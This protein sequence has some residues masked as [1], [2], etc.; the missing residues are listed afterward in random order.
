MRGSEIFP[1]TQRGTVRGLRT[2]AWGPRRCFS[3]SSFDPRTTR[4]FL[5]VAAMA[6]SGWRRRR[7]AR[8]LHLSRPRAARPARDI[9][10][11]LPFCSYAHQDMSRRTCL[12]SCPCERSAAH[13]R[14]DAVVRMPASCPAGG[15][16]TRRGGVVEEDVERAPRGEPA[17]REGAERARVEQVERLD[18]DALAAGDRTR[19]ADLARPR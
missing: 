8:G 6:H 17:G 12:G 11:I 2:P 13:R 5:R 14:A 16:L 15:G 1:Y 10:S 7:D 4:R 19:G 9:V 3:R 18:L